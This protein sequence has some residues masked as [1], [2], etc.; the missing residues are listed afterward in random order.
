MFS[1]PYVSPLSFLLE[2]RGL[3]ARSKI[4]SERNNFDNYPIYLKHTLYHD[5]EHMKKT[6]TLEVSHRFFIY[7]KF[8]DQGNKSFNK[9]NYSEAV[10]YYE[11]V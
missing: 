2:F 6:R 9:G 4:E 10:V 7:D 8:K 11:R 5:D 3:F 1:I